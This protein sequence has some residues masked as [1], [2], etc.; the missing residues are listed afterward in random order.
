MNGLKELYIVYFHFEGDALFVVVNAVG[1]IR[2]GN[3]Y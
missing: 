2:D 3:E 1:Y